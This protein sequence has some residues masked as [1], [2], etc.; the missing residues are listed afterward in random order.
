MSLNL[1]QIPRVNFHE[2]D[3]GG[4]LP[5]IQEPKAPIL[6]L[7]ESGNGIPKRRL[8]G[9]RNQCSIC[10]AYFKSSTAFDQHKTG[11]I[12][13]NRRCLTIGEMRF[14][15]F[16]KTIDGFWCSPV[17][18]KDRERLDRIRGDNDTEEKGEM[19]D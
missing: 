14:Q 12:G 15:N 18:P 19:N 10:H 4:M 16:G 11:T 13:V 3:A 6:H 9:D 7:P 5:L 2:T 1:E 17:A 8:R